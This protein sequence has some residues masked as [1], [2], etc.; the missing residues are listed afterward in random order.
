[1]IEKQKD[2]FNKLVDLPPHDHV[3]TASLSPRY[4][5]KKYDSMGTDSQVQES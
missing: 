5:Y 4:K 1:L 2:N 3:S